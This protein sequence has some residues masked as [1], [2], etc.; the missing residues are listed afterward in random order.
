MKRK[1]K[2]RTTRR[3]KASATEM[4]SDSGERENGKNKCIAN[5]MNAYLQSLECVNVAGETADI[6]PTSD[7]TEMANYLKQTYQR[8]NK[9]ESQLLKSYMWILGTI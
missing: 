7:I 1:V 8:I 6:M 9:T 2:A 3:G 4:S 5:E